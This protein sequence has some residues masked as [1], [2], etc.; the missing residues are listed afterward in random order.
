[1]KGAVDT[2][3]AIRFSTWPIVPSSTVGRVATF[4]GNRSFACPRVEV[5]VVVAVEMSLA[6]S[7][8]TVPSV[9]VPVVVAVETLLAV[10]SVEAPIDGD[11]TKAREA[12]SLLSMS[13]VCVK[14]GASTFVAEV[15]LLAVRLAA[16]PPSLISRPHA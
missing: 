1:M 8:S 2:L 13:C 15:R 6:L 3:A 12:I 4:E 14:T 5:P 11:E 9:G 10:R 7:T 16:A